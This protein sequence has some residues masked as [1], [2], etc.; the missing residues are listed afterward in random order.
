MRVHRLRRL[1]RM[2][3]L[4]GQVLASPR[5]WEQG[6]RPQAWASWLVIQSLYWLGVPP[7]RLGALYRH[8]R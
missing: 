6:G 5:R 2:A 8:I 4:D 7:R 3:Y 1:W